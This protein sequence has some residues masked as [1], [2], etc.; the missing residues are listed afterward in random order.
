[1][2][3]PFKICACREVFEETGML[4]IQHALG[5]GAS[6]MTK[7]EEI[8]GAS[9]EDWRAAAVADPAKFKELCMLSVYL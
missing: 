1:M 3:D 8:G 4:L 9:L 5:P 6:Y 7:A 2:L